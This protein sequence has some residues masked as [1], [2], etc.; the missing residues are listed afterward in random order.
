MKNAL[1][2]KAHEAKAV[3]YLQRRLKRDLTFEEK[4][5]L[6]GKV[7]PGTGQ[8]FKDTT[9]FW[10]A[11]GLSFA[12]REGMADFRTNYLNRVADK[13]EAE[14]NKEKAQ[15][16][17]TDIIDAITGGRSNSTIRKDYR[18]EPR[19]LGFHLGETTTDG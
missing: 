4:D 9:D 18:Q 6:V 14:W 15:L 16:T 2:P 19:R 7:E 13:R 5:E 11:H 12:G 10:F 8:E 3:Q 1:Q 17:N